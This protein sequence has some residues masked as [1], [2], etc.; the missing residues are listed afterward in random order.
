[1]LD[2]LSS[3]PKREASASIR[4]YVYQIYQTVLEWVNLKEGEI[5]FLERAEDFD[6][7]CDAQVTTVQVKDTRASDNITL[8]SQ[9]VI[10]AIGHY[11]EHVTNNP[12]VI[13][14]FRFLTTAL[15]GQEQGS[16]FRG[17]KG[18]NYWKLA[19]DQKAEL[20][21]LKNFLLNLPINKDVLDYINIS[22]DADI[23][24]NIIKPISWDTGQESIDGIREE[25]EEKLVR[26]GHPISVDLN[27]SKKT[28]N[29]LLM[30][31][32]NKVIQSGER[33]LTFYEFET[34]FDRCNMETL[35]RAEMVALRRNSSLV[36]QLLE[37]F[38][39]QGRSS[40][41]IQDSILTLPPPPSKYEIGREILVDELSN[42]LA[43]MRCL[44]LYGSTGL[45][46]TS[47]ARLIG[48][49]FGD[50]LQWCDFRRLST[51]AISDKLKY[52]KYQLEESENC[53]CL[54]LDDLDLAD[55]SQYISHLSR[56][57]LY[58]RQRSTALI[59]TGSTEAS[60]NI[61]E[62]LWLDENSNQ[63]V[64][65]LVE[66]EVKEMIVVR[67][68]KPEIAEKWWKYVYLTTSGHPQ[69]VH[70][71]IWRLSTQGWKFLSKEEWLGTSDFEAIRNEAQKRLLSEFPDNYTRDMAYRLSIAFG[72]FKRRF[73]VGIGGQPPLIPR[74][75][76]ILDNLVGPWIEK[77]GEDTYRISPLL[78]DAYQKV[79][80]ISQIL[81]LHE[82]AAMEPFREKN[83]SPIEASDALIHAF[84]SKSEKAVSQ[85]LVVL[86]QT[87]YDDFKQWGFVFSWF[88]KMAQD[89]TDLI[90]NNNIS[91][92]I[93]LKVAQY[94]I[95]SSNKNFDD[96]LMIIDNTLKILNKAYGEEQTPMHEAMC[97]GMF[98]NTIDIPIPPS[99]TLPMLARLIQISKS[100]SLFS[101]LIDPEKLELPPGSTIFQMMFMFECARIDGITQ[102][103]N[104]LSSFDMLSEDI[105]NEL[106][107]VFMQNEFDFSKSITNTAWLKEVR[108]AE[109][110]LDRIIDIFRKAQVYATKWNMPIFAVHS[111][112]AEA[113]IL[114]E[115]QQKPEE[116]LALICDSIEKF[117]LYKLDLS[118]QAGKICMH[119]E[120]LEESLAYY[121]EGLQKNSQ[122]FVE[123]AFSLRIAGVVAGRL[124]LWKEASYYFSKASEC[125]KR[126]SPLLSMSVGL[127]ADAAF[128]LWQSGDKRGSLQLLSISINELEKLS[129]EESIN[130]RYV[131]ASINYVT[132]WLL[133]ISTNTSVYSEYVEPTP[134]IC[135]N[136]EPPDSIKD[137][138]VHT[139]YVMR[140]LLNQ[141]A[142][143]IDVDIPNTD[144][145]IFQD[146]IPL[147]ILSSEKMSKVHRLSSGVNLDNAIKYM[148]EL[149]EVIAIRDSIDI[150]SELSESGSDIP[151][152]SREHWESKSKENYFIYIIISLAIVSTAYHPDLG[153]PVEV[154]KNDLHEIGALDEK[155]ER[156]FDIIIGKITETDTSLEETSAQAIYKIRSKSLLNRELFIL[157]FKLYNLLK[158]SGG[159]FLAGQALVVM[160]SKTWENIA[161][162][163]AY[164]LSSP[165]ISVPQILEACI[166]TNTKPISKIA[167]ILKSV[168]YAIPITLSEETNNILNKD[169]ENKK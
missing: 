4:G 18:L 60:I 62:K 26:Y 27:A 29:H 33:R 104:F 59:V 58:L 146:K 145:T 72:K 162:T 97:Y 31:V 67:T 153:L 166:E 12:N 110:D 75:G 86:A 113:I 52:V 122:D 107:P 98:L 84:A 5:I 35:P 77:L 149:E 13:I 53:S 108:K 100:K 6:V 128:S 91:L 106:L 115:Y 116:A 139:P 7:H 147:Y 141:I 89:E 114:D 131:Y 164:S 68:G 63:R 85:W 38:S 79:F 155:L 167:Q 134:G 56:L 44:I 23:I 117:K 157:H 83:L 163:Q 22:T 73:A 90:W 103:E 111:I 43:I 124:H 132:G 99:K 14:K 144:Q 136:Q 96:A 118:L 66:T 101:D 64:P 47:L 161:K 55:T 135:S 168:A 154:W 105:K 140:R 133:S 165:R 121:R 51:L 11:W 2:P 42:K 61:L 82:Y 81:H 78:K 28:L 71:R 76:E 123:Q 156:I 39:G 69:L 40:V 17:H 125:A 102:F 45:G 159:D 65:Y 87:S 130:T 20:Y 137:H 150:T 142:V 143:N 32:A 48:S 16:P 112:I 93:L 138:K 129:I 37:S 94:K 151:K 19:G 126:I 34:E 120:K 109:Y 15:P 36:T 41:I 46:K 24:K 119:S 50:G 152:L 8:R 9:D 25:I 95:A 49:R 74:P 3:D 21:P 10:D 88:T 127:L 92:S 148:I 169:I 54:V 30:Y 158:A 1:M 57:A 80:G 70:A 160:M